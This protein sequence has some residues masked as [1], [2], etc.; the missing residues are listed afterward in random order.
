M[1]EI[2][3]LN[4]V[5]EFDLRHDELLR[6]LERLNHQIEQVLGSVRPPQPEAMAIATQP[7]TK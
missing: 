5:Q 3:R 6:D 1:T 4:M 2:D 7:P